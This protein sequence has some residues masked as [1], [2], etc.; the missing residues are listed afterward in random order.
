MLAD[1]TVEHAVLG[2][3]RAISQLGSRHAEE[4]RARRNLPMPKH[5]YG[6]SWLRP[7]RR[8]KEA[9]PLRWA[10]QLTNP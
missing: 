1:D 6:G 4:Y 10:A 9:G 5:G 7:M 2:V 8:L 3:S